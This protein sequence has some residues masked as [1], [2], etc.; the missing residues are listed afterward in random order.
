MDDRHGWE[1]RTTEWL[2]M[3]C[4]WKTVVRKRKQWKTVYFA[5]RVYVGQIV[6]L[7]RV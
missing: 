3:D 6:E 4:L 1:V 2:Y 7:F 5:R